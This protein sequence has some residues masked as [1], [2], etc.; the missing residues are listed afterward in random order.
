MGPHDV[1]RGIG[2]DAG[3]RDRL[4]LSAAEL[5]R[6]VRRLPPDQQD[7]VVLRFP[8]GLSVAGTATVL[9][10]NA[11]AVKALQHRALRRLATL[12]PGGL[13]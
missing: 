9:R 11:G 5:L 8:Q 10:R 13:R 12:L 4:P 7:C 6:C 3:G 2:A 1:V